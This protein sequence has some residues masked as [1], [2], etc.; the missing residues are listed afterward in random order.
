MLLLAADGPAALEQTEPAVAIRTKTVGKRRGRR[1]SDT[2]GPV[3]AGR[4]ALGC[5]LQRSQARPCFPGRS[6]IGI[7]RIRCNGKSSEKQI[8]AISR[9]RRLR[10]TK[11]PF[12]FADGPNRGRSTR[13][14]TPERSGNEAEHLTHL[15]PRVSERA[16]RKTSTEL[17]LSIGEGRDQVSSSAAVVAALLVTGSFSNC[18]S[19]G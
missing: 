17:R 2:R 12:H 6:G 8:R 7:A 1:A 11:C 16:A 14:A 5:V 15:S 13:H 18:V 4:L 10:S 9:S 3:V 19:R